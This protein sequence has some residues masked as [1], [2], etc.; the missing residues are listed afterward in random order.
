MRQWVL[1]WHKQGGNQSGKQRDDQKFLHV[2]AFTMVDWLACIEVAMHRK[3]AASHLTG[4]DYL[5]M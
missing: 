1:V 3:L 4:I 5:P 2:I